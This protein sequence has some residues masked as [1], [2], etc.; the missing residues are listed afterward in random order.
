MRAASRGTYYENE[1]ICGWPISTW[2]ALV[3]ESYDVSMSSITFHGYPD[4]KSL[5][6]QEQCTVEIFK[7][8][9][10]ELLKDMADG[11]KK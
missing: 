11:A 6:E 2:I 10:V 4:G 7:F 3:E 9:L 8:I 5:L 1:L